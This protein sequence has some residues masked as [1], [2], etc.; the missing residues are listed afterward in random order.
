MND[1]VLNE[2]GGAA[3]TIGFQWLDKHVQKSIE[4]RVQSRVV[5][6]TTRMLTNP[7]QVVANIMRVRKPWYRDNRR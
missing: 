1:L 5:I 2:V 4:E 3:L 6:D 7:A